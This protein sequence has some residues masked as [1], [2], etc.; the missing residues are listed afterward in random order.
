MEK[1]RNEF[2][3][4]KVSIE[5]VEQKKKDNLPFGLRIIFSLIIFI[6]MMFLLYDYAENPE[7]KKMII[8]LSGFLGIITFL[9]V[10]YKFLNKPK[11]K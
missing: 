6:P 1:L 4:D 8:G 2:I 7:I 3:E 9:Y 5:N 11:Y 10:V